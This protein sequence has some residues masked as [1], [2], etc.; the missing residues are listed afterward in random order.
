[1]SYKNSNLDFYDDGGQLLKSLIPDLS[2]VPDFVKTASTTGS[3]DFRDYALVI[4]ENDVVSKKFN[5]S[6]AGNTWLS[7][8]YYSVNRD[9]LPEEAQKVASTFIKVAAQHFGVPV[10]S[11]VEQD[12]LPSV[13][14]SNFV[15]LT[16]KAPKPLIKEA[17]EQLF[18]LG[19]RYPIS[20]PNQVKSAIEY[21]EQ[22]MPRFSPVDRR[23]YSIKVASAADT[24]GVTLSQ[25]IRNYSGDDYSSNVKDHVAVRYHILKRDEYEDEVRQDLMKIASFIGSAHPVE[26]AS[27]LEQFDKATGLSNYWDKD[28]MDPWYSTFNQEKTAMESNTQSFTVGTERVT[29]EELKLLSQN[30]AQMEELFGAEFAKEFAGNPVAIFQSMPQT[31]KKILARMASDSLGNV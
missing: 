12:S 8:L 5:V 6:D 3:D 26:F 31:E 29:S 1:M 7:S 27:V 16:G 10:T 23:E 18:A 21:F 14:R 13:P 15:E 9:D 24:F 28:L 25:N 11:I 20:N 30:R 19:D 22:N 17:S 2:E 4:G